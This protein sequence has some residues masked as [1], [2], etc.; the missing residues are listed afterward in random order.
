MLG[1][2]GKLGCQW[3]SQGCTSLQDRP[4]QPSSRLCFFQLAPLSTP[5]YEANYL[6]TN[7]PSTDLQS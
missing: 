7:L 6:L 2:G 1:R 4:H 5:G 3:W